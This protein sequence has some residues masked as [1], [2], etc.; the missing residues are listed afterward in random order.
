[1]YW[2]LPV[3]PYQKVPKGSSDSKEFACNVGDLGSVPQLNV[4]YP[5]ALRRVAE[6]SQEDGPFFGSSA[7]GSEKRSRVLKIKWH[8]LRVKKMYVYV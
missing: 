5:C 3:H 7:L 8:Y 4:K 1:M 2:E 6:F